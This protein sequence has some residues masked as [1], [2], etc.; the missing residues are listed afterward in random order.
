M[1]DARSWVIKSL[2]FLRAS[3]AETAHRFITTDEVWAICCDTVLGEGSSHAIKIKWNDAGEHYW[4]DNYVTQG[5]SVAFDVMLSE[6]YRSRG[7]A[8]TKAWHLIWEA[9]WS[10]LYNRQ[11][12]SYVEHPAT[13]E[14]RRVSSVYWVPKNREPGLVKL[15]DCTGAA[16]FDTS[17]IGQPVLLDKQAVEAWAV[18]SFPPPAVKEEDPA[19]NAGTRGGGMPPPPWFPILETIVAAYR[20]RA[21]NAAEK[22]NALL[23]FSTNRELAAR[24]AVDSGGRWQP[25]A[26]TVSKHTRKMWKG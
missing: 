23:P 11:L 21:N 13:G 19:P 20:K 16:G 4:A 26:D 9:L 6:P 7:M 3:P 22:G 17:M 25:L 5:E 8:K 1:V 12:S 10:A 24:I 14:W 2:T 18:K 15:A